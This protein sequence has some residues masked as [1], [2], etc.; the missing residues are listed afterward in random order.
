V[1]RVKETRCGV[2]S[3]LTVKRENWAALSCAGVADAVAVTVTG[4]VGGVVG[5]AMAVRCG[6][7]VA[8]GWPVAVGRSVEVEVGWLVAVGCRVRVTV[9]RLVAVAVAAYV[10][11]A[12]GIA[13]AGVPVTVGVTL[14]G[15][16][17]IMSDAGV[18]RQGTPL[19]RV[20][21]GSIAVTGVSIACIPRASIDV[22]RPCCTG[23]CW[24]RA[25]R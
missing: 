9:G 15:A 14:D 22:R 11:T 4:R 13:A 16:A 1:N 2:N 20:P 23:L 21:C 8:V 3:G 10:G 7:D 5:V 19:V 17:S 6:V 12:M 24:T 25:A 18:G